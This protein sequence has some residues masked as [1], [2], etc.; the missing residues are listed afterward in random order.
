[1]I[2]CIW[3]AASNGKVKLRDKLLRSNFVIFIMVCQDYVEI[4]SKDQ[5]QAMDELGVQM[6]EVEDR[7]NMKARQD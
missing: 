5:R 3:L 7:V 4:I 1:L 6:Q 2:A